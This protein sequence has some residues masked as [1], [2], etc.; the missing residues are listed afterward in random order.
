VYGPA[1]GMGESQ[2]L[3]F[4]GIMT[5]I[6]QQTVRFRATPDLLFELYVDTRKH[7]ASTGAPAKVSRKV[8][9]NYTAFNGA[10]HGKNLLVLP[11]KRIVQLWRAKHWRKEDSSILILTFSR[12]A[13]GGQ[14]DL[15]HVGVPPYDHQGVREGWPKY[16]WKPW[17]KFLAATENK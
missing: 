16:Y 4:G 12:A 17:K 9:A 13:G 15:V 8:G 6:I 14:I 10:I 3:S 7:S 11:A 5:P 2:A 1:H